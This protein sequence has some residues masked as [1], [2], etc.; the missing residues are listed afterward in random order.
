MHVKT[1]LLNC[2]SDVWPGEGQVLEHPCKTAKIGGILDRIARSR[3]NLRVGVNRS[4]AGLAICHTSPIQ[5]VN[6][7]LTL[8]QEKATIAT[9]NVHP[10]EVIELA[11]I[12][13]HKLPLQSLNGVLE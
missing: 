4:G 3:K 8:K 9:L 12:L 10:Q 5:D 6:H 2:I 13:H 7:I 1:D 11:K